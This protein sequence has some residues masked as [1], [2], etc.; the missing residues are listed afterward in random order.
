[1]ETKETC[2][3]QIAIMSIENNGFKY[4]YPDGT[5]VWSY[6]YMTDSELMEH[7]LYVDKHAAEWDKYDVEWEDFEPYYTLGEPRINF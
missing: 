5:E 7:K 1:M 2:M 4:A 6:D 3:T